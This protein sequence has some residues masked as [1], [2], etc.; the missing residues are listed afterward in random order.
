[1][2]QNTVPKLRNAQTLKLLHGHV[3]QTLL[4]NALAH[5]EQSIAGCFRLTDSQGQQ[6]LQHTVIG[7]FFREGGR[8]GGREGVERERREEKDR[9]EGEGRMGVEREEKRSRKR[10]ERKV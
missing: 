6:P 4:V 1:M 9:R 8:E 7:I 10:R 2:N 5:K 3:L